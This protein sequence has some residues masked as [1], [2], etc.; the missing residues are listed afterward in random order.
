MEMIL[1]T[2]LKA[3]DKKFKDIM[4]NF[5]FFHP[6]IQKLLDKMIIPNFDDFFWYLKVDGVE[7]TTNI[8]ELNFQIALPKHVKRRMRVIEGS[9][10]RIYLKYAFRNK[11]L[12]KE[13]DETIFNHLMEMVAESNHI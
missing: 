3:I 11:K 2:D 7:K 6:C 1:D 8:T 10:R 5:N 9:I 4:D 13:S 12:E